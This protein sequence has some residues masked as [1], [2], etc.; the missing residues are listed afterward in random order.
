MGNLQIT[1]ALATVPEVGSGNNGMHPVTAT[2][3]RPA[4]RF[5]IFPRRNRDLDLEA[6]QI[7]L[8]ERANDSGTDIQKEAKEQEKGMRLLIRIEALGAERE[9]S[10]IHGVMTDMSYRTGEALKRRNAQLTHI[11]I[12]GMWVADAGSTNTDGQAGKQVWVVKVVRR[13]AVVGVTPL[14]SI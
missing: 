8:A 2:A 5:G 10:R 13:E 9:D 3:Q 4:R 1:P 7:E 11:L 6:G 12:N 14:S